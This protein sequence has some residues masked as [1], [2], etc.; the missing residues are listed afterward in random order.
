[1]FDRVYTS[2]HDGTVRA[3]ELSPPLNARGGQH[4]GEGSEGTTENGLGHLSF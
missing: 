3:S 1:M 2:P 4:L